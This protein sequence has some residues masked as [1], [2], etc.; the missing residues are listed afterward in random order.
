MEIDCVAAL[1][2]FV[3]D[4]QGRAILPFRAVHH[5]VR[6]GRLMARPF[7]TSSMRAMLVVATPAHRPVMRLA[8]LVVNLLH[9]KVRAARGRRRASPLQA[10]PGRAYRPSL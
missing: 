1:R 6:D 7:R 4:G 9:A 2:Q 10:E 3:E 5:E 8:K